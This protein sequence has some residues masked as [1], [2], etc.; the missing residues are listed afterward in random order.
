MHCSTLHVD[1]L[2]STLFSFFVFI[3]LTVG[4]VYKLVPLSTT[5][6]DCTKGSSQLYSYND[7]LLNA[8]I[9][10]SQA[11]QSLSPSSSEEESIQLYLY[12]GN[13]TLTETNINVSYS[14]T[15]S[16]Y[17]TA[18]NEDPVIIQCTGTSE[19]N[20]PPKNRQIQFSN[21]SNIGLHGVIFEQCFSLR[22]DD[23]ERLEISSCTFRYV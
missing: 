20:R 13:H 11:L 22:F 9:D 19:D 17:N 5:S 21:T 8:C 15:L 23:L 18:I 14:L 12:P 7:T 10:L 16:S 4:A 3:H 2:S 6:T 1:M